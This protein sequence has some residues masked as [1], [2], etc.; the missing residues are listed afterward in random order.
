MDLLGARD[1]RQSGCRAIA[2]LTSTISHHGRACWETLGYRRPILA[3][4]GSVAMKVSA[5]RQII[6]TG[7]LACLNTT[8]SQQAPVCCLALRHEAVRKRGFDMHAIVDFGGRPWNRSMLRT[9][10]PAI[11]PFNALYAALSRLRYNPAWPL[12]A[13]P[14]ASLYH[15]D[16]VPAWLTPLP[17]RLTA[18]HSMTKIIHVWQKSVFVLVERRRSLSCTFTVLARHP[19]LQRLP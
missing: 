11:C 7:T 3:S 5:A 1:G 15:S 10:A 12:L 18:C 2:T 13:P 14:S 9:V 6:R 8:L 16:T 17:Y 19:R 4:S